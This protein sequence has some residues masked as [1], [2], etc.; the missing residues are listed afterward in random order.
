M[1]SVFLL[2]THRTARERRKNRRPPARAAPLAGVVHH[3]R[4]EVEHDLE[5]LLPRLPDLDLGGRARYRRK[6]LL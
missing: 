4:V 3:L 5:G 1:L 2:Q 6:S